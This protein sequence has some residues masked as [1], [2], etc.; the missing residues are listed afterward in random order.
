MNG[1]RFHD[2]GKEAVVIPVHAA[3]AGLWAAQREWMQTSGPLQRL[4][5]HMAEELDRAERDLE[6]VEAALQEPHS[7]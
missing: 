4:A 3:K 1:A 6:A 5:S 7:T 2:Q